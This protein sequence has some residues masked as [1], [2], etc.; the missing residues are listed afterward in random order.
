MVPFTYYQKWSTRLVHRRDRLENELSPVLQQVEW[1]MPVPSAC[2]FRACIAR[3]LSPEMRRLFL[4]QVARWASPNSGNSFI[5][6][7]SVRRLATLVF[8]PYQLPNTLSQ[9]KRQMSVT[10]G[11]G[12]EFRRSCEGDDCWTVSRQRLRKSETESLTHELSKEGW[13]FWD[14]R[15]WIHPS[16]IEG[17]TSTL[18]GTWVKPVSKWSIPQIYSM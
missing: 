16:M 9:H 12:V 13:I 6:P 11:A 8:E 10:P 4:T 18:H 7:A 17:A 1:D 15:F 2:R 3:H 14:N 5:S